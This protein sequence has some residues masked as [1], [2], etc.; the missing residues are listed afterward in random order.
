[1]N[2]PDIQTIIETKCEDTALSEQFFGILTDAKWQK[3]ITPGVIAAQLV[4]DELFAGNETEQAIHEP[5][6][7][8]H[9]LSELIEKLRHRLRVPV[10]ATPAQIIQGVLDGKWARKVIMMTPLALP[11]LPWVHYAHMAM[12]RKLPWMGYTQITDTLIQVAR[13]KCAHDFLRSE[14]EWSF[15]V[16]GDIVPCFGDPAF[17]YD[18]ERLGVDPARIPPQWLQTTTL[19]R[20]LQAQKTIVGGIYNQRRKFGRIVNSLELNKQ[21]KSANGDLLRTKGPQDQVVETEW[22]ACGCLLV[23]RQVYLDI[24]DKHPE[25]AREGRPFNFFGH[26]VGQGGEDAA[27]ARLALSAGHKSHVDL[28][29]W[30]GHIGNFCFMPED[31]PGKTWA[32]S[33]GK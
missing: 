20:L 25:L 21:G 31:Q 9:G 3:K 1:M 16:D 6:P 33:G 4:V 12:L 18:K 32:E 15:W 27:F 29:A 22:A 23:H 19:D 11:V 17:F 24:M 2:K 30:V 5:G 28:G 14:A 7:V 13:N 10:D 8:L 26:E